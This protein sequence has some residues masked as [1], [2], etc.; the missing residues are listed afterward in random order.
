MTEQSVPSS[1]EHAGVKIPPPLFYV[2]IGL[3][4][5]LLQQFLPLPGLPTLLSRIGGAMFLVAGVWL[6]IWSIGLFRQAET[7]LV[8]VKPS[9][10]LVLSGPYRWTRNP[11]YLGLLL[12]YIAVALIAQI[13]WLLVL[14]PVVILVIQTQVIAREERYLK[15]AFGERYLEYQR[16]VRRW[17]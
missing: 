14:A 5:W 8:P 2:G 3:V 12:C 13:M 15:H 1:I 17:I 9:T 7:S 16:R 11:M 6:G 4:G 10:A